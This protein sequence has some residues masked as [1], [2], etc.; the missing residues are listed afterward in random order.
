MEGHMRRLASFSPAPHQ[1]PPSETLDKVTV[2]LV[3]IIILRL[4]GGC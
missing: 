2:L 4:V 1:E 3:L